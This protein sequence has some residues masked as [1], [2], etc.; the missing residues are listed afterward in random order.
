VVF[1]TGLLEK[2][3]LLFSLHLTMALEQNRGNLTEDE[4]EFFIK[5]SGDPS[6][7]EMA[8]PVKWITT[9]VS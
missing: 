2:H 9:Q 4:V 6:K 8:S 1:P 7:S 5:G 3:K